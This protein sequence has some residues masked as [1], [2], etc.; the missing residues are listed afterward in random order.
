MHTKKLVDIGTA[1]KNAD[2]YED[3]R[4]AF[5]RSLGTKDNL[6]G[7]AWETIGCVLFAVA[8]LLLAF[9]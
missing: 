9:I 7:R 6:P 1:R 5:L 4:K 3:E 8:L 2:L